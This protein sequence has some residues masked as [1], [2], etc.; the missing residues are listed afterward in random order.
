MCLNEIEKKDLIIE[1]KARYE[2]VFQD[3]N[4][5]QISCVNSSSL[6]ATYHYAIFLYNIIEDKLSAIKLL[7]AKHQEVMHNLDLAYKMYIDCYDIIDILT[8]T[9]TSWVIENNYGGV[10][11]LNS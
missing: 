7:K 8:A 5:Y 4:S 11:E 3:L 6:T 9:L 10:N 1:T 2:L